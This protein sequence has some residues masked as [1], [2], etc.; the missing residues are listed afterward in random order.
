MIKEKEHKDSRKRGGNKFKLKRN[1][2][3]KEKVT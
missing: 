2:G 1:N 3:G